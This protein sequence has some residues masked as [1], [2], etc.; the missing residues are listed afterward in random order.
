M[1]D[2]LRLQIG[3]KEEAIHRRALAIA[4]N[5]VSPNLWPPDSFALWD[6]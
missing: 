5:G 4:T 6:T 2:H 1:A 3:V